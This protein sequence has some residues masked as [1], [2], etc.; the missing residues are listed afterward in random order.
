MDNDD[1]LGTIEEGETP[2]LYSEEERDWWMQFI[3]QED[4]TDGECGR[5][6]VVQDENNNMIIRLRYP[7][8]AEEVFDVIIRRQTKISEAVEEGGGN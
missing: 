7:S 8:G 4:F 6:I 5:A 3:L 1:E 2:T